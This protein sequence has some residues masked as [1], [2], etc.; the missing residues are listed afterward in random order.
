ML[1]YVSQLS[2]FSGIS[3]PSASGNT[4]KNA[5]HTNRY[6]STRFYL[7][8]LPKRACIKIKKSVSAKIIVYNWFVFQIS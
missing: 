2:P 5:R 7:I 4:H 8:L 6:Y 3:Q 1:I